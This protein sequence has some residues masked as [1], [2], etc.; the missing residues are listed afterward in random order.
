MRFIYRLIKFFKKEYYGCPV[1]RGEKYL[2]ATRYA[3]DLPANHS[4]KRC[5]T[6]CTGYLYVDCPECDGTGIMFE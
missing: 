4:F 3:N 5:V 2:K 1:C 6:D